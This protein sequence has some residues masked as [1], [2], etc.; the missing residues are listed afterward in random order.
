MRETLLIR[1]SEGAELS[2]R[3]WGAGHT[4]PETASGTLDE[5]IPK[6]EGRRVILL[7]PGTDVVLWKAHVPGL[8]GQKLRQALPFSLE[9][10][11]AQ[12]VETLHFAMGASTGEGERNVAVVSRQHMESWLAPLREHGIEPDAIYPEMFGV[13]EPEESA[14]TVLLDNGFVLARTGPQSGFACEASMF[15]DLT[16]LESLPDDLQLTVYARQREQARANELC[17]GFEAASIHR[18]N[19]WSTLAVLAEGLN[20]KAIDLRQGMYAISRGWQRWGLPYRASAILLVALFLVQL[21]VLSATR[22]QLSDQNRMLQHQAN[23]I[24]RQLFP[25]DNRVV[26]I[27]AQTQSH[28]SSLSQS[29]NGQAGLLFLLEKTSR[30]LNAVPGLHV[31]RLQYQRGKLLLGL[32]GGSLNELETL[33]TK[34]SGLSGVKLDVE[35]A[36]TRKNGV[37]I[38]LKVGVATS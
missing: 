18:K 13:P 3:L 30:A 20:S 4:E 14:W 23:H 26:D 22:V 38:R 35:S 10:D 24:Y 16:A 2:W 7:V 5:V 25:G 12:D 17:A 36:D 29:G 37:R 11:L 19:Y 6:C 27:R 34:F 21:A 15:P 9:D 33:R 8:R 32:R 31:T 28:L 1:L